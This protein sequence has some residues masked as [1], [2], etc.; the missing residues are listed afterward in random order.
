[1]CVLSSMI[2]LG[3][4]LM[5]FA[6][7]Y[8]E[9]DRYAMLERSVTKASFITAQ[10]YTPTGPSS[11]TFKKE[12]VALI[13]STMATSMDGELLLTDASVRL[14]FYM[15]NGTE[16]GRGEDELGSTYISPTVIAGALEGSYEATGNLDGFYSSPQYVV[17]VP[18]KVEDVSV[19]V[20]IA[21]SSTRSMRG[22]L[23]NL[24][25]MFLI[26]AVLVLLIALVFIYFITSRMV[27]P[28]K[29]MLAA[30]NSFS[31]GDFSVR[32]P[33][34]GYDEMG[35]LSM[36]FNNMASTLATT[37]SSRSSFVANVSHELKTPMT[38]IG[39]FIDGILD[40]TIPEEKRDQYLQVVASE[41]KRLSRLV[42]S[43]LDTSRIEAGEMQVHPSHFDISE[44]I[45]QTIFSF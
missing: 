36:A 6:S 42:R 11:G 18:V 39:G 41:V 30:T 45:R 20:L 43:M 37:E 24:L 17:A 32:V 34:S 13:Y 8:F 29:E 5:L 21:T 14:I 28:L 33:V 40:G 31:K 3:G 38:T 15:D 23:Q 22:F 44:I 9:K 35:Q 2:V 7:R 19:G 16:P 10:T 26:S 27:Q 25:E 1:M 12:V 4:V